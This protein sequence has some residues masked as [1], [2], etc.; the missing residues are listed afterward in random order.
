[1][2][3]CV[4]VRV[5]AIFVIQRN[6]N[7]APTFTNSIAV[8]FLRFFTSPEEWQ[9]R[10][11]SSTNNELIKWM[12]LYT[13]ISQSHPKLQ[14][15]NIS[16]DVDVDADRRRLKAFEMWIWRRMEKIS[17]LDK[18]TNEGVLRENGDRQI[19]KSIWQ[20]KQR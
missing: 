5:R 7:V 2:C 16:R 6:L 15:P 20:M 3:V 8:L 4:R 14:Q 11:V 18:V 1:V 19:L 17:W 12:N 10:T 13:Q 9:Q